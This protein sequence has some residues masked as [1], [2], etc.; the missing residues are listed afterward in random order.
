L[1]RAREAA[2]KALAIDPEYAPAHAWLGYVS[3]IDDNDLAGAAQH[4]KRALALDPANLDVLRNSA[5]LLEALGRLDE[6]L[7]LGEA[8]VLRDPVN[9]SALYNLGIYQRY[10]GRLDEAIASSRTVLSLSPGRGNAH[11]QL[12]TAVLLKG[13]AKG[14]LAEIEQETNELWKMIG[15][16]MAYQALGRKADSDASLAALIAKWEKNSPYNIA[17]VYAY[18][19]EADKAFDWLDKAVEYGDP[20][21]GD[22]AVENLFDKI[23]ADPRWLAFLRKVG[24]APEQLAN[25]EFKVTLPRAEGSAASQAQH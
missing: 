7:S 6:A 1:A 9:V 5:A 3:M 11:A 10:A 8:I 2:T 21:I 19:G 15:L 12:G 14:A 4:Y 13:D 18:R 17:Y 24:K 16:P 23:H 20:G 25:I 22:I